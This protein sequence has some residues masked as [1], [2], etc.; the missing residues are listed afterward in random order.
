MSE[1]KKSTYRIA[2]ALNNTIKTIKS[3]EEEQLDALLEELGTLQWIIKYRL[4]G[5]GKVTDCT[6]MADEFLA[7]EVES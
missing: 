6:A 2:A 7:K 1:Y 5:R 3:I 4:D